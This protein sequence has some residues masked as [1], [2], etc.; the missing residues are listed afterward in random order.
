MYYLINTYINKNESESL[1]KRLDA[2]HFGPTEDGSIQ[3]FMKDDNLIKLI[4]IKENIQKTKKC[5]IYYVSDAQ[6]ISNVDKN[7][8]RKKFKRAN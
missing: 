1:K 4:L 5:E 3:Y 6:K 8:K 7:V 2:E